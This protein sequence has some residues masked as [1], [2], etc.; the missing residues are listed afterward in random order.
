[1]NKVNWNT[2]EI[3][4]FSTWLWDERQYSYSLLAMH[5]I[6]WGL[7]IGSQLNLKWEDIIDEKGNPK[8][9][10]IIDKES[11]PI[12]ISPFCKELN[13]MVFRELKPQKSDLIYINYKTKKLIETSNLSKNLQRFS[14]AFLNE[15]Y[16][17]D[18]VSKYEPMKGTTF[19]LAWVL[20]MLSTF[21]FS[22]KSF[23]DV[24]NYIG[25]KTLKEMIKFV[26][27]E[28]KEPNEEIKMRFNLIDA[29][30]VQ[31]VQQVRSK[32][33]SKTRFSDFAFIFNE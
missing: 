29:Q 12:K 22:K 2:K 4:K 23:I 31:I 5:G 8:D 11:E 25:K 6:C 19:Q 10:L 16:G 9:V 28:P 27:F 20:D 7:K 13:T 15:I 18:A 1:M 21:N 17:D 32:L 30:G 3:L 33:S 14:E 26:G 24:G